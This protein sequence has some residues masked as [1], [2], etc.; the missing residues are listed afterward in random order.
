MSYQIV[1]VTT[2][3]KNLARTGKPLAIA[4]FLPQDVSQVFAWALF[5]IKPFATFLELQLSILE[6]P[7]QP[8]VPTS[9]YLFVHD[10][11]H[12]QSVWTPKHLARLVSDY[13]STQLSVTFTYAMW[14]HIVSAAYDQHIRQFIDNT[15]LTE[16]LNDLEYNLNEDEDDDDEEESTRYAQGALQGAHTAAIRD[17]YYGLRPEHLQ[18]LTYSSMDLFG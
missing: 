6:R 16:S 10:P 15:S 17:R 9:D 14:R 5:V 3:W 12:A 18:A 11:V 7:G 13:S 1:A 4:R 2:Y 8:I